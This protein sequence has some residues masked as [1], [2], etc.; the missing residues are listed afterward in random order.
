MDSS[1]LDMEA[2]GEPSKEGLDQRHN[3][4]VLAW[5]EDQPVFN[6]I[7]DTGYI[8]LVP[9]FNGL[10]ATGTP[11]PQQVWPQTKNKKP[12]KNA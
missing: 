6:V 8:S 9:P 5:H 11:D 1:L 3:G 10:R 2:F 7:V 12:Y 4:R